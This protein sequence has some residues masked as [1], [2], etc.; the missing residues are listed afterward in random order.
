MKNI[1]MVAFI[2]FLVGCNQDPVYES[3]PAPMAYCIAE[4]MS[5][6]FGNFHG[7]GDSWGTGSSSMSGLT[8]SDIFNTVK[9]HCEAIYDKC[10]KAYH[11]DFINIHGHYAGN[12]ESDKL[13]TKANHD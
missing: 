2:L 10:F 1:I 9:S 8:Q 5:H 7:Q 11:S 3:T 12:S 4:C 13:A 6:E